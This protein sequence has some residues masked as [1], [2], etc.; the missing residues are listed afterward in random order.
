MFVG[1][2]HRILRRAG[3][4]CRARFANEEFAA[5]GKSRSRI[6]Q[7][8]F[9][10]IET[11]LKHVPSKTLEGSFEIVTGL[12]SPAMARAVLCRELNNEAMPGAQ[13]QRQRLSPT[14]SVGEWQGMSLYSISWKV[15]T[16]WDINGLLWAVARQGRGRDGGSGYLSQDRNYQ[17]LHAG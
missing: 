13:S 14:S 11:H 3:P 5:D 16:F 7:A 8:H 2:S 15:L 12:A 10:M 9:Q 4:L 1:E 17:R 6:V